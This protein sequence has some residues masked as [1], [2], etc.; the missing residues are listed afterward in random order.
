M[1]KTLFGFEDSAAEAELIRATELNAQDPF[2]HA[3]LAMTYEQSG[4]TDKAMAH[5][6]KSYD[7]AEA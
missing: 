5:Y 1:P 6:R 2:M 4:Q 3:L 7:L